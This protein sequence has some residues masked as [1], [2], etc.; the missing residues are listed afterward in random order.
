MYKL[1]LL[2]FTYHFE[3]NFGDLNYREEVIGIFT[4][5]KEVEKAKK[6]SGYKEG[7]FKAQF[8]TGSD[9]FTVKEI[10][11]NQIIKQDEL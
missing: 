4:T 9:E 1:Y 11:L 5:L 10:Q 8:G 6:E 3:E 2:T 7:D